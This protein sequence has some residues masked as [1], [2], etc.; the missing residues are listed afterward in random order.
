MSEEQKKALDRIAEEQRLLVGGLEAEM[1]QDVEK[2]KGTRREPKRPWWKVWGRTW[3]GTPAPF[4][5]DFLPER[6]RTP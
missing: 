2:A 4:E 3:S 5:C 1:Q 6:P